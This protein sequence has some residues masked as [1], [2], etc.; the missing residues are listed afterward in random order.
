MCKQDEIRLVR[1]ANGREIEVDAC[2]AHLVQTLNNA[3]IPTKASCCGHGFRP[4]RIALADGREL[5]LARNFEDATRI[6]RLFPLNI[7]G[8]PS[9]NRGGW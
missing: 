1:L 4:G 3:N 5:I 7:Q 6:D 8:E 2:I 9:Y